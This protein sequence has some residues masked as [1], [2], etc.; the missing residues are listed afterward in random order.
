MFVS[1]NNITL[2]S[3]NETASISSL[4]KVYKF[5]KKIMWYICYN[6]NWIIVRTQE[7]PELVC[8]KPQNGRALC[9]SDTLSRKVRQAAKDNYVPMVGPISVYIP[10]VFIG[11]SMN[12]YRIHF[13]WGPIF[14]MRT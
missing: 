8:N 5:P 13:H 11:W 4:I 1:G 6:S 14:S 10:E 9:Q 7:K 2:F 12:I 3:N